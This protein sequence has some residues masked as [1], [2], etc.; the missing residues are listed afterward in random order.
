MGEGPLVVKVGGALHA[1]PGALDQLARAL[2]ALAA[3]E[4]LVV[5]PGGGPFADAVRRQQAPLGFTEAAAHWMAVLGM[6][7]HAHLLAE[8]IPG[9]CLVETLERLTGWPAGAVAVFA[10]YAWMRRDDPLPHSWE[11]T[12]DSIAAVVAARLGARELLL[13]KAVAGAT[14][15]LADAFFPAACPP[16]L[17]ARCVTT[18]WL[19]AL[20]SASG[21]GAGPAAAPH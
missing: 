12:S 2:P 4:P 20:A 11:A 15:A 1:V 18:E 3:H 16:G 17:P 8:R 7:Q 13:V 6:E 19:L 21:P 10:P 5:V 9:A 14:A